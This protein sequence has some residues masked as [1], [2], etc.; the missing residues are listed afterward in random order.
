MPDV[1]A[2]RE[3]RGIFGACFIR[4]RLLG[5]GFQHVDFEEGGAISQYDSLC[6]T[7]PSQFVHSEA[8]L[9]SAH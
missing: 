5:F 1:G 6:L 3:L 2:Q 9:T 7:L 4:P 8:M